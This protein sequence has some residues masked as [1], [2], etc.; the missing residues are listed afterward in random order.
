MMISTNEDSWDCV[1]TLTGS[2]LTLQCYPLEEALKIETWNFVHL[3][4]HGKLKKEGESSEFS[5]IYST[6]PGRIKIFI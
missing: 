5:F 6:K 4:T 1:Y 3:V 2:L